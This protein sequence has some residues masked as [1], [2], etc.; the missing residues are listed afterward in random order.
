MRLGFRNEWE[1]VG[2]GKVWLRREKRGSDGG[3]GEGGDVVWGL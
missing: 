2:R 3:V 1:R